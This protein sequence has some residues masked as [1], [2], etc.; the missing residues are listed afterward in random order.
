MH[1]KS[2]FRMSALAGAWPTKFPFPLP[3]AAAIESKDLT[4]LV[5]VEGHE[6]GQVTLGSPTCAAIRYV[7]GDS[8]TFVS[9]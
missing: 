8:L 5:V 6:V 4:F 1:K 3:C 7:D 2:R 9:Q